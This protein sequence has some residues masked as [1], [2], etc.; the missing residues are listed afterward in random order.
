[1]IS[2]ESACT[3]QLSLLIV[4]ALHALLHQIDRQRLVIQVPWVG[5]PGQII[6]QRILSKTDPNKGVAQIQQQG[7]STASGL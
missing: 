2:K 7:R 1:M 4:S 3:R 5:V 6:V